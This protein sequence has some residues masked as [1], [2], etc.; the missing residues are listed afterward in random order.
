MSVALHSH[1]ET[2]QLVTSERVGSTLKNDHRGLK[3]FYRTGDDL[4]LT[5]TSAGNVILHGA[6]SPARK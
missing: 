6:C 2:P 4:W 5:I 3:N 1:V